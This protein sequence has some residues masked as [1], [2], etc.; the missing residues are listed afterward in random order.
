M[1]AL[2]TS[3]IMNLFLPLYS[4]TK[5]NQDSIEFVKKSRSR[6]KSLASGNKKPISWF[7]NLV[8][9]ALLLISAKIEVANRVRIISEA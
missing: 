3:E 6:S 8:L 4:I 7:K 1:I 2:S 5:Q 9:A